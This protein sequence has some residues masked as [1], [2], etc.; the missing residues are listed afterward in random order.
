MDLVPECPPSTPPEPPE[1]VEHSPTTVASTESSCESFF[2]DSVVGEVVL[3]PGGV[4]KRNGKGLFI[5]FCC[6]ENSA[7]GRVCEAL[8]IPYLLVTKDML[9]MDEQALQ[10]SLVETILFG[11]PSVSLTWL[12]IVNK[13]SACTLKPLGK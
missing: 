6:Q 11:D 5:E 9:E 13:R 12:I 1:D 8:G 7:L 10:L 2:D 3:A 4:A